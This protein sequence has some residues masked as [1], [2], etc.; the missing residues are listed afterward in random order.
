MAVVAAARAE[1]KQYESEVAARSTRLKSIGSAAAA[2]PVLMC[3]RALAEC[4]YPH[5]AR[6]TSESEGAYKPVGSELATNLYY[7]HPSSALRQ[8]TPKWIVY[9]EVVY[10]TKPFMRTCSTVEYEWIQPLLP[11]LEN[12]NI[13]LLSGRPANSRFDESTGQV[14]DSAAEQKAKAETDEIKRKKREAE[15]ADAKRRY[16]ERKKLKENTSDSN[17]SAAAGAAGAAAM[18]MSER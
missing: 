16:A 8:V 13:A 1:R 5:S 12:A 17:S 9:G 2:D 15:V 7:V 11:R 6:R 14:R 18:Q 3:R 4:L 10:T